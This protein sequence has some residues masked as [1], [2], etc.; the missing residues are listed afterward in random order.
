MVY[1]NGANRNV[2]YLSAL[3]SAGVLVCLRE[4]L[5]LGYYILTAL[6]SKISAGVDE[7]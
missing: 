4:D 2:S 5:I 7:T 1:I 3:L 6:Y